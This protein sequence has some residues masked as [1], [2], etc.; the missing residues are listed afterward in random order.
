MR[1]RDAESLR[2]VLHRDPLLLDARGPTAA[3]IEQPDARLDELLKILVA[4][5]DH[6]VGAV[7]H[8]L[9]RQ[10]PDHVVRLVALEREDG[11]PVRL[12][13]LTDALHPRVEVRL[14]LIGQLL[15]RRLVGGIP[16]VPKAQSR[17]V[18]PAEVL[19]L[20]RREEALEEIHHPP[21]RRSVLTTRRG[22]RAG[23]QREEG[24][25][26]QRV[27]VD[28]EEPRRLGAAGNGWSGDGGISHGSS[29]RD[30]N[31]APAGTRSGTS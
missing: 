7:L 21:G 24:A 17:I 23:D 15:A 1:G 3:G 20:M 16:F 18:D 28:Q 13:D 4:R 12:E 14:E 26:D 29:Q 22:E 2:A 9:A 10:R 25:I 11:N 31:S 30:T 8:A 5:D 27:A 19:R 6:H